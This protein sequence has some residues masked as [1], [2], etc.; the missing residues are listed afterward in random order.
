M[1]YGILEAG[2]YMH[3]PEFW[4]LRGPPLFAPTTAWGGQALA[5]DPTTR[6]AQMTETSTIDLPSGKWFCSG[7]GTLRHTFL[8]S[9]INLIIYNISNLFSQSSVV[10]V[11]AQFKTIPYIIYPYL[12]RI[13][14]PFNWHLRCW[15]PPW[16]SPPRLCCHNA[17]WSWRMLWTHRTP[18]RSHNLGWRALSDITLLYMI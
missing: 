15:K 1:L 14:N 6:A 11:W 18:G 4:I 10:I 12:S 17:R 16:S 5:D 8:N 2:L 3:Q 13:F 9:K 7:G